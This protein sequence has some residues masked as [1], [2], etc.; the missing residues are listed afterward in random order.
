MYLGYQKGKIK[1]YTVTPLDPEF[2]PVDKWEE[3]ENEYVLINDE[4]VLKTSTEA[5]EQAKETKVQ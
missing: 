1:F 3:T 5:L 4:Y 2:Y